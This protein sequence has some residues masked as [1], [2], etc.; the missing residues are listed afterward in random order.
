[1]SLTNLGPL[2][3]CLK[4]LNLMLE[5]GSATR[6]DGSCFIWACKQNIARL[7]QEGAWKE[8][9]PEEEEFRQMVI[10]FMKRNRRN[11]TR[12]TYNEALNV[13]QDPE[14]EDS[15]FDELLADQSRPKSWTD[16]NGTFVEA[17]AALFNVEIHIILPTVEGPVLPSGEGGPYVVLNRSEE[18]KPIFYMGLLQDATQVKW[19]LPVHS[20][21]HRSS[22][23][24]TRYS[25]C[26][27]NN[28]SNKITCNFKIAIEVTITTETKKK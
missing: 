26:F 21:D 16:L 19:P 20:S 2:R 4:R 15:Q 28:I 5:V 27:T 12:V 10:S 25:M 9:I 7:V 17:T 14:Y 24:D 6:A 18:C 23:G 22:L 11:W 13:N 3:E 1:M 8:N